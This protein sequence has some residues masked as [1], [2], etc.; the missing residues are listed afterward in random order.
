[1]GE[2]ILDFSQIFSVFS[3]TSL[4]FPAQDYLVLFLIVLQTFLLR[5]KK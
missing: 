3:P 4:S 1:M 5:E 2:L